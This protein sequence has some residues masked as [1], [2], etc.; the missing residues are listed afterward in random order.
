M[1]GSPLEKEISKIKKHKKILA[2]IG[3]HKVERQVYEEAD[4]NIAITNQPHSEV[5]AL[6][7]FLYNLPNYKKT[8]FENAKIKITPDNS[9]KK[10]VNTKKQRSV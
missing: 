4:Y 10:I 7:V 2:I 6:A 9:G 8:N 5:A 3:S 1:Y